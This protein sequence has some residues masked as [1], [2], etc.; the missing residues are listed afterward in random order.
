MGFPQNFVDVPLTDPPATSS[1]PLRND[2][3]PS[4]TNHATPIAKTLVVLD[5]VLDHIPVGSTVSN[6]INLGIKH[7]AMKTLDPTNTNYRDYFEHLEKKQTKTCLLYGLPIVGNVAKLGLTAY[8]YFK[9]IE[10]RDD[11]HQSNEAKTEESFTKS[12]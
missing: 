3:P 6:V 8:R 7:V 2:V 4:P 5:H 1:I 10:S 12:I 9:K 11:N